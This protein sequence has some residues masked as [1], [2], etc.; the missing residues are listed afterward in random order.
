MKVPRWLNE[1]LAQIF[2]SAVAEAGELRVG[3]A[4]PARLARVKR[5]LQQTRKPDCL[6]S[7]ADLLK[8]RPRDFVVAHASGKQVAD[9]HYLAA[10]ALAITSL[11]NDGCSAPRHWTSTS[12]PSVARPI[13]ERPF[14]RWSTSHCRSSRR[15]F[16]N[17]YRGFSRTERQRSRRIHFHASP[18]HRRS[19]L[20]AFAYA[21]GRLQ[22]AARGVTT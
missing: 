18:D 19:I 22:V 12:R 21:R 4:D 10:W 8:A 13:L 9:R 2:E 15:S 3:Q 20:I 1:G 14:N 16:T 7:V 17:I 6:V 11:S 5:A